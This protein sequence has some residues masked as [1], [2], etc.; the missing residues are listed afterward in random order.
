VDEFQIHAIARI[1]SEDSRAVKMKHE[2]YMTLGLSFAELDDLRRKVDIDNSGSY[3]FFVTSLAWFK[4][5]NGST[6][7]VSILANKFT[8]MKLGTA[9]GK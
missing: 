9:V 7:T 6:A 1:L 2:I 5:Q 4:A 3:G 8:E